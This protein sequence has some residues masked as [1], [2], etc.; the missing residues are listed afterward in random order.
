MWIRLVTTPPSSN[1]CATR[2]RYHKLEIYDD[3]L[4]TKKNYKTTPA[5]SAFGIPPQITHLAFSTCPLSHIVILHINHVPQRQEPRCCQRPR[6]LRWGRQPDVSFHPLEP[7]CHELCTCATSRLPHPAVLTPEGGGGTLQMDD[8]T[9]EELGAGA[10]PNF[11]GHI[12]AAKNFRDTAGV[13]EGRPGV[14]E[15]THIDPLRENTSRQCTV[16]TLTFL[17]PF[18]PSLVSVQKETN[19]RT[20]G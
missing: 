7:D 5:V 18:S 10:G 16:L 20:S 6:R 19:G 15:S 3:T 4:S 1:S 17:I 9:T 8:P 13:V 12:Q 11:Q 14:I 2:Y